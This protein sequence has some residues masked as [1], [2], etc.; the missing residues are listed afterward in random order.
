MELNINNYL[1]KV[2]ATTAL[3]FAEEIYYQTDMADTAM[4]PYEK[5]KTRKAIE[6]RIVEL[7]LLENFA[8]F[9]LIYED[10]QNIGWLS[11]VTGELFPVGEMY[12]NF[13]ACITDEKVQ[14]GWS[15]GVGGAEDRIYYVKRL[16]PKAILLSSFYSK[17]LDSLIEYSEELE[18]MMVRLISKD[19]I[20]LYSSDRT[21]I[22]DTMEKD[23]A[24]LLAKRR[25]FT[26]VSGDYIVCVTT[27]SNGWR[28][29]CTAPKSIVLKEL[30]NLLRKFA[31]EFSVEYEKCQT[32]VSVGVVI[33]EREKTDFDSIYQRADAAL[34][35][36]KR[37]GKNQFTLY[38][39]GMT[40]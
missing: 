24:E 3:L 17:E 28:T 12:R 33:H 35:R 16:N 8:D 7:G 22:G 29:V 9:C 14:D 21:E 10:D 39:E 15:F 31:K 19:K 6:D 23:I 4:D 18:G 34:Y 32:S 38:E 2:E 25:S 11:N 26:S 36:S 1:E 20:I 5:V 40:C 27:C 30:Q 13:T 37:S